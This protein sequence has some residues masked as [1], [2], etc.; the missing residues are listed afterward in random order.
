MWFN[1]L[2]LYRV[3]GQAQIDAASLEGFLAEQ[4]A[5]PVGSQEAR[6]TGW[7]PPAGRAGTQFLHELQGQRLMT[8]LRQ[9]RILPS[10]VVREE[11]EE[12]AAEI[13]A[14]EGRRLLRREKQ[15]LKEQV[16]EELLPQAFV[17]SQRFDV[18]WD[19]GRQLIGINAAS[20]ARAEEALDLLRMSL[21]SLK[22]TPLATQTLPMR[23]MTEWLADGS[24]RP[25][26]LQLGNRVELKARGDD[27]VVR[28]RHVD[29]DSDEMQQHL[30][31]GRQASKLELE[32]EGLASFLLH[33][34]LSIK[35]LHFADAL[36]D[37]ASETENDD[38]AV[39]RLET[40]FIIMA[41]ALGQAIDHLIEWMGGEAQSPAPL[42][43]GATLPDGEPDPI[44]SSSWVARLRYQQCSV[45]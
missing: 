19:T 18:W 15:E 24:T 45:T 37:E 14:R 9:E 31:A 3:H 34:D 42:L 30:A 6:R 43:D 27:G 17:R 33:D 21:G 8:V 12:R 44:Y 10:S 22:V 41:R 16:F 40:D 38:D 1:N 29:L 4:A 28:G 7:A 5:R 25:P 36:L 2:H 32:I 26:M 23:A 39:L 20:R 13:E 35:G 11:V